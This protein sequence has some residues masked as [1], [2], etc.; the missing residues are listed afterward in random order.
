MTSIQVRVEP[1]P[2]LA[3]AHSDWDS[4]GHSLSCRVVYPPR[5]PEPPSLAGILDLRFGLTPQPLYIVSGTFTL[6]LDATRRFESI[7]GYDNPLRWQQSL[8]EPVDGAAAVAYLDAAFDSSGHFTEPQTPVAHYD[9]T[10]A[11]LRLIWA[12]ASRWHR[13]SREFALGVDELGWLTQIDLQDLRVP[14][15][16]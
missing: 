2:C 3:Q 15:L 12:P 8:L 6:T 9:R 4:E 1:A 5:A 16:G 13:I 11:R 10:A 14:A 7:D